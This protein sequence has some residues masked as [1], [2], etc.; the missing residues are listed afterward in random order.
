MKASPRFLALI[1]LAAAVLLSILVVLSPKFSPPEKNSPA[2]GTGVNVGGS[3]G[4]GLPDAFAPRPAQQMPEAGSRLGSGLT[5]PEGVSS[6][7]NSGQFEVNLPLL[8]ELGK[9]VSSSPLQGPAVSSPQVP[10]LLSLS[11]VPDSELAIDPGGAKDFKGYFEYL[12]VHYR[13][14]DFDYN[15]LNKLLRPGDKFYP[16]PTTL[17]DAALRSGTFSSTTAS[18]DILKEFAAAK[19]KFE[20]SVKVTGV[21]I[22]DAK[23]VISLDELTTELIDKFNALTEGRLSNADFSDFYGE[24]KNTQEFYGEALLKE[25]GLAAPVGYGKDI[26]S[27]IFDALGL[28]KIAEAQLPLGGPI[29]WETVCTCSFVGAITVG[30]PVGGEFALPPFFILFPFFDP[31]I[32]NYVLGLYSPEPIPCLQYV[33]LACLPD[34]TIPTTFGPVIMLGTTSL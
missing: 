30:P 32:G 29:L 25:A 26:F 7:A 4:G 17:I 5:A 10:R 24:Y 14:L 3:N 22:S 34:P 27:E 15:N 21:A 2:A 31:T 16:S 9:I 11:Q 33:V 19:I 8:E 6:P 28:R 18:L 1:G 23:T 12:S 20:K 13:G